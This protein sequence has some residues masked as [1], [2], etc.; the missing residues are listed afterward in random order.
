MRFSWELSVEKRRGS[1]HAVWI[2]DDGVSIEGE[3]LGFTPLLFDVLPC[4][5]IFNWLFK[6]S[7]SNQK[8]TAVAI[9]SDRKTPPRGS[10]NTMTCIKFKENTETCNELVVGWQELVTT[11]RVSDS[12]LR[13][14][15]SSSKYTSSDT[16]KKGDG[17]AIAMS[18]GNTDK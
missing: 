11:V 9:R 14:A 13:S 4:K 2:V 7:I 10:F 15:I 16:L 18:H 1:R 8:I 12:A 6:F 5:H 17:S 3:T